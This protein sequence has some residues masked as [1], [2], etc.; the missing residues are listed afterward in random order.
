MKVT[1][2]QQF[3]T[4]NKPVWKVSLE[5]Q[6][7]PLYVFSKP[8][9]EIG[10]DYDETKFP[11]KEKEGKEGKKFLAL[12][13]EKPAEKAKW[14]ARSTSR[15]PEEVHS[16]ESQVAAKIASDLWLGDKIKATDPIAISLQW[17]VLDKLGAK[18]TEKK[19][20]K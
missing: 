1:D 11:F 9:W 4:V 17:W 15:S 16:I 20:E 12:D 7:L 5:G 19:E 13:V 14:Q 2:I 3:G 8:I 10:G 18:V 6:P